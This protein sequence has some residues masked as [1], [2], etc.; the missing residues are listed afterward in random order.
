MNEQDINSRLNDGPRA[1]GIMV[2]LILPLAFISVPFFTT[3]RSSPLDD[4]KHVLAFYYDWY[5]NSSALNFTNATIGVVDT[6]DRG[7]WGGSEPINWTYVNQFSLPANETEVLNNDFTMNDS[8]M[9]TAHFPEWGEYHSGDPAKIK[10]DLLNAADCGVDTFIMTWWGPENEYIDRNFENYMNYARY[11]EETEGY[12]NIPDFTM[13]FEHARDWPDEYG[14]HEQA[15]VDEIVYFIESY[16]DHPKFFKVGGT[17]VIFIWATTSR[18]TTL[19]RWVQIREAVEA[20]VGKLYWHAAGGYG[21][22]EKGLDS[23]ANPLF[24]DI[25]DGF[26]VYLTASLLHNTGEDEEPAPYTIR[27]LYKHCMASA[28]KQGINFAPCIM[29]GYDDTNLPDRDGSVK[30][31]RGTLEYGNQ[32]TYAGMW[33]DAIA[34]GANWICIVTWNEW[35]EGTEIDSSYEYGTFFLNMTGDYATMLKGT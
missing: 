17:P 32:W 35:W 33:E 29:P 27:Q 14:A 13:Y 10:R 30:N 26:H 25:F 22:G 2:I 23:L 4:E 11:L 28:R 8:W 24:S 9:N 21:K 20:R 1:L 15:I 6:G 7:N 16:A 19:D 34:A 3:T 12:T 5:R 18:G 31:R